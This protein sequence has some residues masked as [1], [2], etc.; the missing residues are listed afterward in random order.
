MNK[1]LQLS[2]YLIFDF[3]SA[4]AA[5]AVF[6]IYRKEIIEPLKFGYEIPLTFGSR[7]FIAL[8]IL[9]ASWLLF[10]YLT[11]F[12][13]NIFRHSRTDDFLRTFIQ[14]I[15]GVLVIFFLLLLDDE[16]KTYKSYYVL[17]FVL[18]SLHFL[19]TLIP[20]LILTSATVKKVHSRKIGFK[21]II[22]GSNQQAIDIYRELTETV[23]S[24]GNLFVGFISI[25]K[26]DKYGLSEF[27]PNLGSL[28]ELPTVI[29]RENIE[30]VIIALES[31]EHHQISRIINILGLHN[32]IIKAI[33][34]MYD[35]LTGKVKMD[36]LFGTPLILLSKDLM[37]VWQAN[38]K[39]LI[40]IVVSVLSLLLL[41]PVILI[42]SIG[43]KLS[44]K[45]PVFYSHE[46]I[47][48][49]G[50][51]FHIYKFR[52]MRTDAEKNGPELSSKEDPRLTN[53]GRFMRK[54]RLDEIPN[55]FNVLKGDMSLVGPRPERKFFIDQIIK[56]APHYTHLHKVK[57]GITSWGQVKYGYAENVDQM[58]RRLRYDILYIENMSLFVD[59]KILF[60]TVLTIIRGRG[61]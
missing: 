7:F 4:A 14:S 57:P 5:W 41:S 50:K 31:S 9:P 49:Y 38:L 3:L 27:I 59:F 15:S 24:P 21:S 25:N 60:Y 8:L 20:R 6:Y 13:K 61:V 29:E 2:R 30:E 46:R 44:S 23:P 1:K 11:G 34:D 43:V 17:F 58:I 22:I 45:G 52:S 39:Q 35:I 28:K 48:K 42:L 12:Y 36:H 18:F 51:P 16:I 54:Y 47:G 53:F 56:R 37:P 33:P 55:F 19:F 26:Q 40:D 32:V 10:Y